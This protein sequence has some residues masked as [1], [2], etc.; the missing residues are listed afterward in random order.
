M[1]DV[2]FGI[3]EHSEIVKTE[4]QYPNVSEQEADW[5]SMTEDNLYFN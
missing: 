5:K 1:R 2:F 3:C 4:K